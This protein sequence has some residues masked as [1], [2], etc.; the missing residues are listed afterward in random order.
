MKYIYKPYVY[1]IDYEKGKKVFQFDENGEYVTHDEKLIK[2]M[3]EHKNFIKCEEGNNIETI[4]CKKCGAEFTNKGEFLAHCRK[5]HPK[6][7]E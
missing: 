7:S 2:W 3:K 1:V 5:L 6:G 4:K